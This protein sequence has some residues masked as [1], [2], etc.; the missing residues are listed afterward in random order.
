MLT[1]DTRSGAIRMTSFLRDTYVAD[2]ACLPPESVCFVMIGI[3]L[4]IRS[5]RR[6]STIGMAISL[7][8]SLGY[9]VVVIL[10]LSCE[11]A[12]WAHPEIL[13]WLPVA[14]CL[15][16]SVRLMRRHL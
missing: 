2:E 6:E 8:V 5:Q 15:L 11:E 12:Y 13:I 16:F 3:P 4:G 10:M 7:A 1:V 14:A 9:Y